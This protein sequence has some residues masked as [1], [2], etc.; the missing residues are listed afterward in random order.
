MP[1]RFLADENRQHLGRYGQSRL[2]LIR[3]VQRKLDIDRDNDVD[4]QFAHGRHRYIADQAT[5]DQRMVTDPDRGEYS[6]RGHT[7]TNRKRQISATHDHRFPRRD[8]RRDRAKRYWQLVKVP[9]LR[10]IQRQP[11]QNHA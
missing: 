3:P 11:A 2:K 4:V 5:V 10:D 1:H 9:H 7:G 6:G 8:I